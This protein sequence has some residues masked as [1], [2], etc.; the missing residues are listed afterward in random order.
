MNKFLTSFSQD[1]YELY[2]R[3]FLKSFVKYWDFP[4]VVYYEQEPDFEHPN[5]TYKNLFDVPG[6]KEFLTATGSTFPIFRGTVDDQRNYRFDVHTFARKMFAQVDAATEHQGNL[7][8]ID[9]DTE[10]KK[11]LPEAW[12]DDG[13]KEVFMAYMGRPGWHSCASLVGWDTTHPYAEAFFNAYL[14]LHLTGQIFALPEWHDSFV[15]DVLRT[16]S[17]LPSRN[18]AADIEMSD[19]PVNVFDLVMDGKAVHFKGN[20]KYRMAS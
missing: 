10:I 11:A 17:Q 14:N 3:R 2:G 8:W 18:L 9:A 6:C 15:L 13:L 5:V 19:G 1:G 16:E 7:W 4:I 12:L 20:K